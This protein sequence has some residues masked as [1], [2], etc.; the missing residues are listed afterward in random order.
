MDLNVC[1]WRHTIRPMPTFYS[2]H[3]CCICDVIHLLMLL[4]G[5]FFVFEKFFRWCST[6]SSSRVIRSR[7]FGRC[8]GTRLNV[9]PKRLSNVIRA[10]AVQFG[11]GYH[12]CRRATQMTSTRQSKF[13]NLD[14]RR[15][16][17]IRNENYPWRAQYLLW[18]VFF[19]A[20]IEIIQSIADAAYTRVYQTEMLF[21]CRLG[22]VIA[23]LKVS[24][25]VWHWGRVW[26]I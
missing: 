13:V 3:I 12:D 2:F 6:E 5:F 25:T 10:H 23:F 17:R 21:L 26:L 1:T 20:R 22:Q 14:I 24:V 8:S 15:W 19:L 16:E 9:L 7:F 11:F 4:Y 18:F